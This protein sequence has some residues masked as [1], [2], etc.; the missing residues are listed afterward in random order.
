MDERELWQELGQQLRVDA[1][2]ASAKAGSG[3]SD[4][5]DVGGRPRGRAPRGAPALR[6]RR[7]ARPGERPAR[8]LEGPRLAARLRALQRGRRDLR[9]G[10]RHLPPVRLAAPGPSDARA[11]RGSTSRPARSARGCRSGSAWRSPASGSN[12]LPFRVWVIC[13]D[14]EMAEGSMWEAAEHAAFYELDHLTAIVDVNRLG[15][16][17]ETMHGWDLS[18]YTARASRRSAGTRS[19][20]TGTTSRRSTRAYREAEADDRSADRDRRAHDQGQGLL[21]GRERERLARQGDRRGG[22]RRSSAAIRNI[23]GRRRQAGA[24]RAR[25]ASSRQAV[26]WP[27][28]AVGAKVST[29]KAY[30]EALAALGGERGDVVVLDG[31]VSNSTLRR[32]LQRA[33]TPTGSSRCTSPSSRW[34]RPRSG[35][36]CSAGR[37]SPRRSPPSSPARTTSSAWRPSARRR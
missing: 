37:R 8:L 28:Y 1:V 20:S 10:V 16:R 27:A 13:G 35:C 21:E 4:L 31:E 26:D 12:R 2:R 11:A 36:R 9:G 18:S 6:L 33:R 34:S 19:R 23:D 15:Q 7:A 29:R 32:A 3:P 25:T 24:G 30:G 5:V 14:S 22:D 17:G